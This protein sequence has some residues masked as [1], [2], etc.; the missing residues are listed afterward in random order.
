[1]TLPRK[2]MLGHNHILCG[3]KPFIALTSF[4]SGMPS[5][6]PF[7]YPASAGSRINPDLKAREGFRLERKKA[8]CV[9]N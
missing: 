3:G 9:F 4:S 7:N 5:G 8:G 2:G 6:V 1:M